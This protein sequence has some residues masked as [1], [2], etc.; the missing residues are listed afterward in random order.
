MRLFITQLFLFF[1]VYVYAQ[2][3]TAD[4]SENWSYHFQF[5]T[6]AQGYPSFKA[7]YSGNNS[8]SDTGQQAISVTSTLFFGRRLWKGAA[9]YFDPEL[10][11]GAGVSQTLGIAGFPNGETFRIGS[12]EPVIYVGRAY[13]QQQFALGGASYNHIDGDENQLEGSAPD[14]SITIIAGKFDMADFF[15]KNA[16]SNDPRTQFMNWALM[17]NGAW[18]YPAN[19]RGY[20][21]GLVIQYDVPH[22]AIR[23]AEALEPEQAN[24]SVMQSDI[25]EYHSETIEFERKISIKKL[26]G[27]WRLLLYHNVTGAPSYQA[28]INEMKKGDST[29]LPIIEGLEPG[30][31]ATGTKNGAGLNADQQLSKTVGLFLRAG[32][33]DGLTATWAFTEVDNTGSLGCT[34]KGDSW[35]RANDVIGIAALSNGISDD[36]RDYLNAGGYGY[37]IGDGKL[38][39]YGREDI[40]EAYYDAQITNSFWLTFDYQF[41]MNPAYNEDRGPVNLF[42]LR[43]HIE[44]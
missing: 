35:K 7:A 43:G 40:I 15:D 33:N 39:N 20:T 19:T 28:A 2:N 44:F 38:T 42:A 22:W 8:L 23:A 36:H 32:W 16:Y 18:D 12:A 4:S 41:V 14:H 9:F 21:E 25:A 10:S 1:S 26:T 29:L 27:S 30:T 17:S 3:K 13:L 6:I 11:G 24:H 34:I 5:T 31:T 37:L